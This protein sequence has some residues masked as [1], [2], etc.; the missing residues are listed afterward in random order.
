M[1][2]ISLV[3]LILSPFFAFS[4]KDSVQ[5]TASKS[6]HPEKSFYFGF[7]GGLNFSNVTNASAI[8]ASHQ[9]GFHAGVLVDIGTK[10]IGFRLEVLYSQQGYGYTT[11]SSQ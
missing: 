1:K 6:K 3:L 5:A 2:K 4:Q 8:S 11:D 10:L 9:T 7:K